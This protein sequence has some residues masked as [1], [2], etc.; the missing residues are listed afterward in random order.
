MSAIRDLAI[1]L[2]EDARS[3]KLLP[4]LVMGLLSGANLIVFCFSVGTPIFDGPL[5][6]FAVPGVGLLVF[7]SLV[8][9]CLTSLFSG[10]RGATAKPPLASIVVLAGIAPTLSLGGEALFITMAAILGMSAIATGI[11]FLVIGRLRAT[12]LLRFIPYPVSAGF[13]AGTGGVLCLLALP[14]IGLDFESRPLGELVEPTA[15]ATWAPSLAF[16]VG[17]FLA[18]RRW[19]DGMIVPVSTLVAAVLFHLGLHAAGISPT[20]AQETGL[21]LSG[22]VEGSM[23]PSF[24]T[25][26]L[27]G[28]SWQSIADRV[29]ELLVV[30]LLNVISM[31][32]YLGSLE[33][34]SG[35]DVNWDREFTIA[36]GTAIS[37]AFAAAPAPCVT[38]SPTVR[39]QL[40]GAD[41]RLTGLFA[42]AVLGLALA[43]G[44]RII[45]WIPAPVVG[46][47]LLYTGITILN[48]WVVQSS[49]RLP[50]TEFAIILVIFVGILLFGFLEAVGIGMLA[51]IVLFVVRLSRLDPIFE[52]STVRDHRSRRSRV[53]PDQAIL[54]EQGT[55]GRV[56]RLRGYVFFGS[57]FSLFRRLAE[58]LG[59]SRSV[60]IVLDLHQVSG[61]DFSAVSSL[62]GFLNKAHAARWQVILSGTRDQFEAR[63]AENLS[64]EVR[65][66]LVVEPDLDRA[67]ERCEDVVINRYRAES[68][69]DSLRRTLLERVAD[70]MDRELDRQ[71]YFEDIIE[72]LQDWIEP[73][74]YAKGDTLS[75]PDE[76]PSGLQLLVGGQVSVFDSS[77][78]RL[79]QCGPGDPVNPAAVYGRPSTDLTTVADRSCWVA[80]LTPVAR[81][82]L[83]ENNEELAF[84]LY[85]YLILHSAAKY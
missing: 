20:E 73:H 38:V 10:Y 43:Y 53:I 25:S 41:S 51:A 27:S 64:D 47:I 63:L 22:S 46:G 32:L 79:R 39:N 33:L 74:G 1:E 12:G 44:S 24:H 14:L 13:L 9:C 21:L 4:A 31:A 84:K 30:V 59:A 8:G 40:V 78:V 67:V 34:G 28:I 17:L 11:C 69:G 57:A 65:Y 2:R 48:N 37:V 75:G 60:C 52:R 50:W 54:K 35:R 16:G 72:K 36:G 45:G 3:S 71:A 49:R 42:A 62:C 58:D 26:D 68:R 80:T 82:L 19:R 81:Q 66:W 83:E 85:Q 6:P 23:W 55:R 29:P 70:E 15:V 56:Y 77:G 5:A 7:S 76:P 18:A 61:F